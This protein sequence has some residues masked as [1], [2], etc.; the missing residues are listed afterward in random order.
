MIEEKTKQKKEKVLKDT[1][2]QQAEAF[3]R[4]HEDR[5]VT[6]D[7]PFA[8]HFRSVLRKKKIRQQEVFLAADLS[9]S[10]GYKLI[11]EEKHTVNRD[12]ILRLCLG[13]HFELG[14]TQRALKLYGMAPLYSR[15][16]RDAVIMI[17]INAGTYEIADVDE[18]LIQNGQTPLS[19]TE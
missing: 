9:E 14:E 4:D 10:Y 18:L 7:R 17:A 2:P 8:D 1:R 13:G 15:V 12:T 3:L 19:R 11:S 16:P 6:G 5:M